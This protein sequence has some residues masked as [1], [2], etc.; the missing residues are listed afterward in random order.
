MAS[1]DEDLSWADAIHFMET[2]LGIRSA[3][4]KV[5][6]DR[7]AFLNELIPAFLGAVPMQSVTLLARPA[8]E[9]VLPTFASI[10]RAVLGRAGGMC[11]ELNLFMTALLRRLGYD[12]YNVAA[13]VRQLDD[14][15]SI[16]VR[17]LSRP[18]SLHLVDV[19]VGFPLF[20]AAPMPCGAGEEEEEAVYQCSFLTH[21]FRPAEGAPGTVEWLHRPSGIRPYRDSELRDGGR[22]AR[23]MSFAPGRP[24]TPAA[25]AASLSPFYDGRQLARGTIA[26]ATSPRAV[27]FP[28]RRL[29]AIRKTELLE[30]QASG[31]VERRRLGS[32]REL[33]AAYAKYFPQLSAETVER[34]IDAVKLY[35]DE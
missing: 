6:A 9:R 26:F 3:A 16:V 2:V 15:V 21:T 1:A 11:Y 24:A 25:L 18:G 4:A 29:L 7:A 34:A 28:G 35:P 13:T 12:A 19:G 30:E 27:F 14:H 31:E 22:W 23:F 17:D 8:A 20:F 33:L 5:A 10:R 32:R